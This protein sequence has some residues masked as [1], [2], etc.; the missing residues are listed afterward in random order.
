MNSFSYDFV[1]L[2]HEEIMREADHE[3]L[4]HDAVEDRAT[5]YNALIAGLGRQMV[6][7]GQRLQEANQPHRTFSQN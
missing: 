3:R 6:N 4:V 5:V 7:L 1:K 2:R